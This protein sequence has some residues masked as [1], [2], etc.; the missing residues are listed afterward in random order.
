M[1]NK[2]WLAAAALAL[3][4]L[5]PVNVVAQP[6]L[7]DTKRAYGDTARVSAMKYV[8]GLDEAKGLARKTGKPIFFNCY[9]SW[10]APCIAMDQYVF[11]NK[12][13]AK[14]MDSKFVNLIVDM[15]SDEGKKLAKQYAVGSYACYIVLDADGNVV[16]RI[17]GGSGLPE[18]Y[19][20]VS[21]GLSPKTSLA[22][23]RAKYES[24]KY[25]KND[26]Y[27]YLRALRVAGEGKTWKEL[28]T[29]YVKGMPMKAIA[30]KDNWMFASLYR[31]YDND[32]YE[33]L[34][35][36]KRDFVKSVGVQKVENKFESMLTPTLLA[37]ACG[38]T[39]YD[40][41]VVEKLRQDLRTFEMPDTCAS[42]VLCG[43][44]DARGKGSVHD[45]L[46]YM[47]QNGK[48]LDKYYGIR[49]NIEQTF[50]FPDIMDG[51]RK[52]LVQY[53]GEAAERAKGTK[54]GY[55]L[56][57]MLDAMNND[58]KGIVFFEGS[59]DEALAKA[60]KEGKHV[61]VDCYTTWCGP[62]RVMANTVF[63]KPQVGKFFNSGFVSVKIDMERGEGPAV[64]KKYEVGAYP[65]MLVLKADGSVLK[66]IVGSKS[67]ENLLKEVG[68]AESVK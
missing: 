61:F 44:A 37:Y 52:E 48:Y 27:R 43:I 25:S 39:D 30:E 10:A 60:A 67:A 49:A 41:A 51:E 24:G 38:E 55:G 5:F 59:L 31:G 21:L 19:E 18:F 66:K 1:E 28:A 13:F 15:R 35:H 20:N 22:G 63:T 3:A 42:M 53:L 9:A 50:N 16:Q 33:Y 45:L 58:G 62:C 26:L 64:G 7:G 57:A 11:S 68:D 8:Y 36:H 32:F 29:E 6:G 56:R 4:L 46:A 34:L 47:G 40:T 17:Q 14:K 23:L 12:D 54:G 2:K 65:T